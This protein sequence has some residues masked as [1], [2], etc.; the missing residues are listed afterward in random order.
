MDFFV[1]YS[2]LDKKEASEWVKN[3]SALADKAFLNVNQKI[4]LLANLLVLEE[5]RK[6]VSIGLSEH[7]ETLPDVV[8]EAID[9]LWNYLL[10][11]I[12]LSTF[13]Y[14]ANNLY[15]ACLNYEVGEDITA[16]N[17]T[18]IEENLQDIDCDFVW[19]ILAFAS[20]LMVELLALHQKRVDFDEFLQVEDID[21]YML[22]EILNFLNDFAIDI[23][24]IDSPSSMAKDVIKALD[25]AAVSPFF[26]YIIKNI[27]NAL[28]DALNIQD[29]A[30]LRLKYHNISLVPR[31]HCSAMIEF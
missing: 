18:F 17:Q 27:Q 2:K 16:E 8:D 23:S 5:Y 1:D 26:I 20:R 21:F 4:K 14:F 30:N 7:D 22:D 19:E 28:Q 31:E 15:A 3:C 13:E 9:Y 25:E 24:N 12:E 11:N 10:D 6:S 29:Y